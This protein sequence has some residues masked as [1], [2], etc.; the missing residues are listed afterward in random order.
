MLVEK[1]T[2]AYKIFNID[3][4]GEIKVGNY[5][6]LVFLQHAPCIF[7]AEAAKTKAKFSAFDNITS[8]ISIEHVFVNGQ[9]MF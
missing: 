7:K 6:N 8:D 5:A 4:H 2:A 9:Q 1:L 3:S